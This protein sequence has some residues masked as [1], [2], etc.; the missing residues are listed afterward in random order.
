MY[1]NANVEPYIGRKIT[2]ELEIAR[3]DGSDEY[4]SY[5]FCCTDRT[6]TDLYGS[7]CVAYNDDS[8]KYNI[9]D[10]VEIIGEVVGL[11]TNVDNENYICLYADDLTIT[12]KAPETKED[13]IASCQE[14][15]YKAIA[16]NPDQY[17]GQRFKVN[18]EIF[19]T[20]SGAWYADYDTY[21][22]AYTDDGSA[23]ILII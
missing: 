3:D 15:D 2:I 22:K 8:F 11:A 7:T 9:G 1:A 4:A 19:D 5:I 16:R 10:T 17:I 20:F 13:F 18:V 21:Y 14:F 23:Y 6:D 12:K